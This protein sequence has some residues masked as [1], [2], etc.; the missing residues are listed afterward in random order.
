MTLVILIQQIDSVKNTSVNIVGRLP[1][2]LVAL[3]AD[4]QKHAESLD[5][6]ILVI[7]AMV[8]D[9]VLVHGFGAKIERVTVDLDFGINVASWDESMR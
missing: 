5:I 2:G 9:L 6:D 3:Y 7:G 8:R 1:A 4:I